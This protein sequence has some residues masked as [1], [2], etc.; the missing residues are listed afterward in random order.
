[1]R[2]KLVVCSKGIKTTQ[3]IKSLLCLDV[4]PPNNT[5]SI[6]IARYYHLC[7]L[8]LTWRPLDLPS[9]FS[10]F[11]IIRRIAYFSQF[12]LCIETYAGYIFSF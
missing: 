8:D 10:L 7:P 5:D 1:M 9:H 3:T 6:F 12:E 4:L 2:F 11:G